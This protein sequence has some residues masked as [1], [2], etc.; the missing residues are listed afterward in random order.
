MRF[1]WIFALLAFAV[2]VSHAEVGADAAWIEA[3]RAKYAIPGLA[4]AIVER[5]KPVRFHA[6]GLCDV[7]R[8]IRCSE[9]HRFPIGSVTK[10]IT[11]LIAAVL[12]SGS[13]IDL[14][15]PATRYWPSL[16]LSDDRARELTLKDLLTQRSGL[17]SVDW[18]YYWDKALTRDDYLERL[19]AVPFAKP[20]RA[21]F[22]YANANFVLA[23]KVLESAT[24][25]TWESLVKQNV[26]VPLGMSG[27]GFEASGNMATGYGPTV[28]G[29]F[30]PVPFV[31]PQAIRPAGGLVTTAADFSRLMAMIVSEGNAGGKQIVSA[32]AVDALLS[33]GGSTKR[34]G[35]GL[36]IGFTHFRDQLVFHHA[37]SMAGHSAAMLILPGRWAVIVLANQT[38]SIFPE[39]LAFAL[40]D[41]HMGGAGDDALKRFGGPLP[42]Q[43]V[44]EPRQTVAVSPDIAEGLVGA[45]RHAAWGEFAIASAGPRLR[46]RLGPFEAALD[47]E[48]GDSFS[49]LAAPGWERIGI[50]FQRDAHGLVTGFSML[51]GTNLAPQLFTKFKA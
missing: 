46:I 24:G 23:G 26:L 27:S 29:R 7:E 48:G 12:A 18:P 33:T 19:A 6:A 28:Q 15:V 1:T 39:G 43:A 40:L 50:T 10:S 8:V 32:K 25:S 30:E 4:I 41:R 31:S 44:A 2:R 36:G 17:G 45:Y 20:F 51:D 16:R 49:F 14:D 35:Y 21:G 5:D 37:G 38:A 13:Q 47:G 9:Q 3:A 42:T 34:G 11:G 22:S